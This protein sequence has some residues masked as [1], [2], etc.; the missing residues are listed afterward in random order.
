[1]FLIVGLGNP[2]REYEQTR[3]NIGFLTV[4]HLAEQLGV[5]IGRRKCRALVGELRL[6]GEKVMLAKPQTYMNSSGESVRPL[7]DY[8]DV[9]LDHIL[10]IYDDLDLPVGTVRI[11][12][13][14]SAGTH[15]GMRS[16]LQHLG[17]E[18]V[19]RLRI[20]IGSNGRED[21]IDYVIG[22]FRHEDV[23]PLEHAIERA[24]DAIRCFVAEGIEKAMTTY[25]G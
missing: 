10:V 1:M 9:P 19:P 5:R 3:H 22:G 6:D 7:A 14:G 15:N 16:V 18:D 12:R 2:G 20:G 17:S 11:R 23:E 21:I 4:D 24:C 8:Y 25:N 13:K